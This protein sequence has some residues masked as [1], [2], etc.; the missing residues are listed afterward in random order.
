LDLLR[1]S[2]KATAAEPANAAAGRRFTV[3]TVSPAAGPAAATRRAM[4][5]SMR[6]PENF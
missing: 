3:R 5:P 1:H 6:Q 4:E 2:R